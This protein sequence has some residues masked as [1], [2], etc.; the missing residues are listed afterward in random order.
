MR[1]SNIVTS[2]EFCSCDHGPVIDGLSYLHE[3]TAFEFVLIWLW[4]V[5]KYKCFF[6]FFY[7]V[8]IRI[9][10]KVRHLRSVIMDSHTLIRLRASI[11]IFLFLSV[12][13]Y[14]ESLEFD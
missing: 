3:A 12:Y 13:S 6:F 7:S 1:F 14:K 10:T 5:T 2:M 8:V 4:I 11:Y 9:L